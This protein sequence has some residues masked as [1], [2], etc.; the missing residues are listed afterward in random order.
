MSDIINDI[1][2]VPFSAYSMHFSVHTHASGQRNPERIAN[3]AAQAPEV[4]K[5]QVK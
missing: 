4:E 1:P 5:E 3:V 2:E